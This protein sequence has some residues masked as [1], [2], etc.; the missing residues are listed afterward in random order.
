MSAVL[1]ANTPIRALH[2]KTNYWGWVEGLYLGGNDDGIAIRLHN[3]VPYEAQSRKLWVALCKDAD[4][5]VDI[6]AHTG[7]YS[8]AAWRAGAKSVLSVE[9][10]HLNY[11]RLVMNL[12][13]AGF[14]TDNT[15]FCA[16]GHTDGRTTLNVDST[17]YYCS[18]G[19]K[20]G[21]Q[22]KG[23]EVG[24][25]Y[26]VNVRRLDTLLNKDEQ[27][28]VRVVKIDT[29]NHGKFVLLGMQNILEHH[30][31]LILECTE[32]GMGAMLKPLGYKFY[33]I[34]ESRE[35]DWLSR[36]DDLIPD[37]PFTFDSPN[38]YATVKDL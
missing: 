34:H 13:H 23:R 15:V 5:V 4:L 6:G 35:T 30:P 38:R 3:G 8:L 1:S 20:V 9:P 11:A 22:E 25:Q 12:H 37:D 33:K 7:I 36:V 17:S 32:T 16:A 28:K 18:A 2:E 21:V 24:M 29:E 26:P 19:G 27:A 31:D 10:Y 14:S